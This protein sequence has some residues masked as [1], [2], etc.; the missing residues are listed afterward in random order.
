MK[1]ENILKI[2]IIQVIMIPK[3]LKTLAL[4]LQEMPLPSEIIILFMFFFIMNQ[5]IYGKISLKKLKIIFL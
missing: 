3:N 1:S 2:L 4:I 5:N